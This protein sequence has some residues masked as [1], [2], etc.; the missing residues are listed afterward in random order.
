LIVFALWV[1]FGGYALQYL[2]MSHIDRFSL[3]ISEIDTTTTPQTIFI[4]R[5]R[6]QENPN[7]I[8]YDESGEDAKVIIERSIDYSKINRKPPEIFG[9][10]S[11]PRWSIQKS[12]TLAFAYCVGIG[13][14]ELSFQGYP[15]IQLFLVI[16]SFIGIL[17]AFLC[18]FDLGKMFCHKFSIIVDRLLICYYRNLARNQA[19]VCQRRRGQRRLIR[20]LK[21]ETLSIDS[22]LSENQFGPISKAL[23][24]LAIFLVYVLVF[25]VPLSFLG[26]FNYIFVVFWSFQSIF[27]FSTEKSVLIVPDNWFLVQILHVLIGF[28][29]F[30]GFL[31]YVTGK[32]LRKIHR[33]PEEVQAGTAAEPNSSSQNLSFSVQ[34][35]RFRYACSAPVLYSSIFGRSKISLARNYAPETFEEVQSSQQANF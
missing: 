18:I 25:S 6:F 2:I 33:E 26:Y 9:K 14:N 30:S 4:T 31:H 28:I 16:Y 29:I 20:E 10:K 3:L 1:I 8:C 22:T 13:N 17:I 24:F 19:T 15:E 35:A 27:T 34:S 21:F 7:C 12:I 5:N 23:L 11:T 32:W